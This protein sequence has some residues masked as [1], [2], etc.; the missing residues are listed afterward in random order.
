ML[1]TPGLVVDVILE[2]VRETVSAVESS[3]VQAQ[4]A[5]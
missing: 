4:E 1:T 5:H 3:A 2:A